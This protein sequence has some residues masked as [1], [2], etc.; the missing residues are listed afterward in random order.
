MHNRNEFNGYISKKAA[1]KLKYL[2]LILLFSSF[3]IFPSG[4]IDLNDVYD[5]ENIE[6]PDYIVKHNTTTGNEITNSEA[7][8]GR[9]LFYDK[10]LSSDITI[11]CASC[12][13]QEFAFGDT[14]RAS[15][16]VNGTTGRHSMRLVN[17]KF[18]YE[19]KAF[20]DERAITFEVQATMPIRDHIEMGYSGEN[21]DP[22]FDDLLTHLNTL[23]YYPLLFDFAYGDSEITE[24]RIQRS[25]TQFIKSI[26][27][28]DSKYDIGRAQ[29]PSNYYN[30]P[31]FTSQE[32][33]GRSLFFTNPASGGAGCFRCHTG[34]EISIIAHTL[35][36]GIIGVIGEEDEVDLFV[37]KAPTLRDLVN[38]QGV[39]NGPIMHDGSLNSLMEVVNHYND[40]EPTPENPQLDSRLFGPGNDL[41]FTQQQKE[42][43]VA[44]LETLTG[45]NVYTDEQWS[46][47]FD[48][49]GDLEV[50]T[51]LD[52]Q[53]NLS[54]INNIKLYP[55]PTS[56]V[57]SL[58]VPEGAY[59]LTIYDL[60]G[61]LIR[62]STL[63]TNHQED[64]SDLNNGVYF[65]QIINIITKHFSIQKLV[66]K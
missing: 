14:E 63:N 37:T 20:W 36:N 35:N 13:H 43:L 32:N 33:L 58:Q 24:Y 56:N 6:V 12:H 8:L 50:I 60:N 53:D 16:G 3:I 62:N 55:N 25:L 7:T 41:N 23:E 49:N 28:F 42:A 27:S 30:F 17:S 65:V 21:G 52:T 9:V 1:M 31:N 46:D 64:I 40:L 45:N 2:I 47:P 29:V 61:K 34:S 4:I 15:I 38:P 26:T 22:N 57:F 66:K 39:L 10:N 19:G 54:E 11:S 51:I 5:Y 59:Q 18:T 48:E 44:F